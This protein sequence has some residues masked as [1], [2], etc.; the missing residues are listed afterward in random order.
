MKKKLL[1]LLVLSVM[2]ISTTAFASS[3]YMGQSITICGTESGS[4]SKGIN[5]TGTARVDVNTI[6]D[7]A[8]CTKVKVSIMNIDTGKMLSTQ[9][10]QAQ[11][12]RFYDVGLG[13]NNISIKAVFKRDSTSNG[14]MKIGYNFV[15]NY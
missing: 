5:T 9:T 15:Y 1:I 6:S 7:T 10:F 12:T 4:S 13:N 3:G 14:T 2:L 8:G 11:N